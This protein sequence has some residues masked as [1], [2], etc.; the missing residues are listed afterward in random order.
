METQNKYNPFTSS[1]CD[2][3]LFR[4]HHVTGRKDTTR[5]CEFTTIQ[6]CSLAL[7]ENRFLSPTVR[8]TPSR[9]QF[10]AGNRAPSDHIRG[11]KGYTVSFILLFFYRNQNNFYKTQSSSWNCI[12][13]R[14]CSNG[15]VLTIAHEGA[16]LNT[17]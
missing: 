12:L 4:G 8:R 11:A 13:R 3:K 16:E 9:N 15:N 1:L 17:L 14:K 6:K 10:A 7:L 2:L 5:L